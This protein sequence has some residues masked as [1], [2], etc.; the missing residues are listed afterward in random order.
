MLLPRASIVIRSI[1]PS[2]TKMSMLMI[3]WM[4]MSMAPELK[5][6]MM[7]RLMKNLMLIL[8]IF[9]TKMILMLR[10]RVNQTSR[11]MNIL[12]GMILMS[13]QRPN[14]IK[15]TVRRSLMNLMSVKR[16]HWIRPQTPQCL[17]KSLSNPQIQLQKLLQRQKTQMSGYSH[18][19]NPR[20]SPSGR[21]NTKTSLLK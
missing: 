20:K 5:T 8:I 10:L 2:N 17:N 13:N 15:C 9:K 11:Y 19:L 4:C 18:S 3:K 14:S 16:Q 12:A 6:I 7:C 1:R 21:L